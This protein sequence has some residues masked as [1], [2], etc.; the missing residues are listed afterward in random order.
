MNKKLER[1]LDQLDGMANVFLKSAEDMVE[2]VE[3]IDNEFNK[4]E[5]IKYD[6]RLDEISEK[7]LKAVNIVRL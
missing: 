4:E 1:K 7:I 3:S 5:I 6:D 2:L